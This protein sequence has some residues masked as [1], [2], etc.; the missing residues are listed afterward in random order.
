MTVR[1][2]IKKLS[3]AEQDKE[4]YIE[5]DENK[6]IEEVVGVFECNRNHCVVISPS[7]W[8]TRTFETM[9]VEKL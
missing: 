5:V 9:Q 8:D 4:V 7:D 3:K 1:E 6:L 2:L